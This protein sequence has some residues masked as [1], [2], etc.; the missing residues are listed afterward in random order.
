MVL[1][2][3]AGRLV[4]GG[5]TVPPPPETGGV[6]TTAPPLPPPPPPQAESAN[7]HENAK[8]LTTPAIRLMA[9]LG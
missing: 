7:R 1:V 3:K 9:G 4:V 5:V 8:V 2:S 6:M